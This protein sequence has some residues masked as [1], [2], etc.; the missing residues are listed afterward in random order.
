MISIDTHIPSGNILYDRTDNNGTVHL[1]LNR[2]FNSFTHWFYFKVLLDKIASNPLKFSIDNAIQSAYSNGWN[3]YAPFASLDGLKW[4]RLQKGKLLGSAFNFEVD[5]FD[6]DFFLSW[7]L[8]YPID[9]YKNWL[10]SISANALIDVVK[11][12]DEPDYIL[13]GDKSKPTIVIVSRQHPGESMASFVTEGF[14]QSLTSNLELTEK[15]LDKYSVII[16]PLLNI[17]GVEKGFHRVNSEGKDLNRCWSRNDVAEIN[18]VKNKLAN[19]KSIH[20]I[21]DIHGDEVSELNYV[22]YND[23]RNTQ[24]QLFLNSLFNS[25]PKVISLPEQSFIKRFVKHLIRKRA[26]LKQSGL[27]LSEFGRK[28]YKANTYTIE[29]SAKITSDIGCNDIGQN[30]LQAITSQ[31]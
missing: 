10:T 9:K 20:S 12:N 7:Y 25:N 1:N 24:Q 19:F 15:I 21:I 29:V 16:F 5:D 27:P 17:S 31:L 30:I 3:N 4:K 14:V 11:G 28:E 18:F 26:I 22:F 8:P 6:K 23:S 2:E 13:L